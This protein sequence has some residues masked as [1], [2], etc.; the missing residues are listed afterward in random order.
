M[1]DYLASF[2]PLICTK[3][4]RRAVSTYGLA[5]FIDG[6]C[7]HEPDFEHSNPAITGLCR[8]RFSRRLKQG[9]RVIYWTKTRSLGENYVVAILKVIATKPNHEAAAA[10]YRENGL[11]GL[12]QNLFVEGNQPFPFDHTHGVIS[13]K[14]LPDDVATVR[15]WDAGYKLR[16]GEF[17]DVAICEFV[18]RPNLGLPNHEAPLLVS[19]EDKNYIFGGNPNT[20]SAP[21]LKAG[22]WKR[23]MER[24]PFFSPYQRK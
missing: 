17:E 21:K 22:E 3:L 24:M 4:G 15:K 1:S 13:F 12:P 9:D 20:R 10:W 18:F 5:E 23:F 2:L 7:R 14:R 8:P 11:E 19:R 6:S 16:I